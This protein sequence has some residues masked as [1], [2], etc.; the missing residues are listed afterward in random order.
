VGVAAI[1]DFIEDW[2]E[3]YDEFTVEQE[4]VLDLGH[5][6]TFA[7]VHQDAR[8]AGSAGHV[9]QREGWVLAWL[10]GL[11]V[12]MTTYGDIDEA[13]AAAE[14]LAESRRQAMSQGSR[15]RWFGD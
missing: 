5:G 12:R 11:T 2:F 1:R 10:D 8:P 9:R 7:V 4:E 13:R 15:N 3:A 14:R 6:V